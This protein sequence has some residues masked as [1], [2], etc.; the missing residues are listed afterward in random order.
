MDQ[1]IKNANFDKNIIKSLIQDFIDNSRN[2]LDSRTNTILS[3]LQAMREENENLI[4]KCNTQLYII[5]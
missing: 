3:I 5:I 1:N 2:N 4:S